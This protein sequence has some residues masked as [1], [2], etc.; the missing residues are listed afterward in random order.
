MTKRI[1]LSFAVCFCVLFAAAQQGHAAGKTF[2]VAPFEVQAPQ[3]Y[4]Y[5]GKAVASTLTSRLSG[6]GEAQ[7]LTG[8]LPSKAPS[9]AQ[10]AGLRKSLKAD[11]LIY[12]TVAVIGNDCSVNANVLDAAGKTKTFSS[13]GPVSDLTNVVNGLSQKV[14]MQGMQLS[15]RAPVPGASAARASGQNSSAIIVNDDG[16]QKPSE[17]YLNPQFRYQGGSQ[18]D[19]SR[20]HSQKLK[21][22]MVDMAVADFTGD[23]R[24]EVAVLGQ[25]HVYMYRMNGAKLE[26]LGESVVS[27]S[28][29]MFSMRAIDING[30]RKK[31]LVIASFE[32]GGRAASYIYSFQGREFKRISKKSP[33]FLSAVKLP[34]RYEDTLVGQAWDGV[35]LFR[36]GVYVMNFVNGD[37]VKGQRISL[38]DGG[39]VFGFSYMRP[40]A[41]DNREKLLMYSDEERIKIFN[42]TNLVH[43]TSESY[44]GASQGID[45]YKV[46]DGLG[47]RTSSQLSSKYFAPMRTINYIDEQGDSI[48]LVNRPVSTA[49]MLFDRYRYFPQGEIQALYWDGVGLALKWK[50]RRIKGSVTSVDMADVNNDGVTELVVG[51]NTSPSLGIGGRQ[52]MIVAYPLDFTRT[53]PNAPVDMSEMEAYGPNGR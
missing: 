6:S 36:P 37:F 52:S 50:T 13:Q 35:K 25:H 45:Y 31:E 1:L 14:A 12:G 47:T 42:G 23:G 5:L 21:Y 17:Y 7:A 43:T 34:P 24:N 8:G 30:D 51:I 3:G 53:N 32:S 18:G 26:P 41:K 2:A 4:S 40:G 38:P 22:D 16:R 9:A 48:L 49:S 11:Y 10:A 27:M 19:G 33:Y 15:T 44:S 46:M 39:K 20:L 29:D 28:D